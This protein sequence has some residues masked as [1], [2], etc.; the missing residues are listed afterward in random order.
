MEKG[1]GIMFWT[2][3]N[4]ALGESSLLNA[5]HEVVQEAEK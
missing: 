4:D 1:S 2:L 3:E 5:I